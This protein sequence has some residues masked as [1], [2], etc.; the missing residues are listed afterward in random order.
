MD[1]GTVRVYGSGWG[2]LSWPSMTALL[3]GDRPSWTRITFRDA[4]GGQI[5]SDATPWDVTA[6][7]IDGHGL[8]LYGGTMTSHYDAQGNGPAWFTRTDLVNGQS[9][10]SHDLWT[11]RVYPFRQT[12]WSPCSSGYYE[13]WTREVNHLWGAP[14][15]DVSNAVAQG[16]AY[17]YGHSFFRKPDSGDTWMFYE[18]AID[19]FN[20]E[21]YVRHVSAWNSLDGPEY[22]VA[23]VYRDPANG[24][25]WPAANHNNDSSWYVEGPRAV[26]DSSSQSYIVGFSAGYFLDDNYTTS[27]AAAKEITGPYTLQLTPDGSNLRDLTLG[28]KKRYGLTAVGRPALFWVDPA[29]VN[30]GGWWVLFHGKDQNTYD[31]WLRNIYLA[32]VEL[33]NN[34]GYAEVYIVD[35][36][37]AGTGS[38][39][40]SI[41]AAQASDLCVDAT[42]AGTTAGT[43]MQLYG[44]NGTTYQDLYFH[45][46]NGTVRMYEGTPNELCLTD[47]GGK[48]QDGDAVGLA[49]CNQRP[50]QQWFVSKH[51][52]IVG[53]HGKCLDVPGGNRQPQ[54]GLW[55]WECNGWAP[56]QQWGFTARP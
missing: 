11:R 34:N 38:G 40:Y 31:P 43:R 47:L 50:E 22:L 21:A 44:C 37:G 19:N 25:H 48:G 46:E 24:V 2:F 15:T 17:N 16:S 55:L 4:G 18:R 27:F 10:S 51:G 14:I 1:D 29:Q 42:G 20:I 7:N 28:L 12:Y 54:Q 35:G 26:W 6:D 49:A 9:V 36:N 3:R 45:P 8:I 33:Y 23:P 30:G 56:A 41:Q 13:E 32:P 52:E 5:T 53:F 39:R